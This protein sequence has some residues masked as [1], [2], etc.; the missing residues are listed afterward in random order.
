M[1]L[2]QH[3]VVSNGDPFPF[4]VCRL[5]YAELSGHV[6]LYLS[7]DKCEPRSGKSKVSKVIK[8]QHLSRRGK[9]QIRTNKDA[10]NQDKRWCSWSGSVIRRDPLRSQPTT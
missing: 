3:Q 8:G 7:A 2:C 10:D 4:S 9:H 6:S 5:F 1:S